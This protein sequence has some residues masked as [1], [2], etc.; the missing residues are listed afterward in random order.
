MITETAILLD[1]LVLK[2]FTQMHRSRQHGAPETA[3]P[4]Y[5]TLLDSKEDI[6]IAFAGSAAGILHRLRDLQAID[7]KTHTLSIATKWAYWRLGAC[8]QAFI[9]VSIVYRG[10]TGW[11]VK[12][13][14]SV[15]P[16]SGSRKPPNGIHPRTSQKLIFE[17]LCNEPCFVAA[18]M[19]IKAKSSLKKRLQRG[20][21]FV[22]LVKALG[23]VG[24]RSA[25]LSN[26]IEQH[27]ARM[28]IRQ[29]RHQKMQA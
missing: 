10:R 14:S 12:G 28:P 15:Y 18:R 1:T 21:K 29:S 16:C 4:A 13:L 25:T 20:R 5:R 3:F 27:L 9:D 19:D 8:Y 26:G 2:D 17:Q 7:E 23:T 11:D 6:A 24:Q 22:L